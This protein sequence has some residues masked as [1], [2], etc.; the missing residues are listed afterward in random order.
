MGQMQSE[1]ANNVL[2]FYDTVM[3]PP[4]GSSPFEQ[5]P[6]QIL[7]DPGSASSCRTTSRR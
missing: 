2:T 7:D 5:F 4:R 6:Q 3:S 1:Y